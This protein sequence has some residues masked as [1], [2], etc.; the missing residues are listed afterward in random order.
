MGRRSKPSKRV[1]ADGSGFGGSLGDLLRARGL[2]PAE[3]SAPTDDA[4]PTPAAA[5]ATPQPGTLR[6]RHTRKGRGGK[7]VTLV[8]GLDALDGSARSALAKRLRKA[9]G[10]GARVEGEAIAVQ[11]DAR[12]AV[13]DWLDR[14]G[15]GPVHRG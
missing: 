3:S 8:E 11:G 14:D 9:L 15:L 2:A 13:S 4:A 12:D 10:R 1:V 7:T 5:P 6:V